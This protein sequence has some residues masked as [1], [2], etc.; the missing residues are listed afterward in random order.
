MRISLL[1]LLI[2]FPP[3]A[4]SSSNAISYQQKLSTEE[5]IQLKIQAEK[6]RRS[7]EGEVNSSSRVNLLEKVWKQ[8]AEQLPEKADSHQNDKP[9]NYRLNN[10][11]AAIDKIMGKWTV[12]YTI[13]S[14]YTDYLTI[15]DRYYSD[16]EGYMGSGK[17][18]SIS[19]SST[20]DV[21]LCGYYAS[22]PIRG[23]NYMCVGVAY[24]DVYQWYWFNLGSSGNSINGKYYIGSSSSAASAVVNSYWYSLYGVKVATVATPTPTVTYTWKTGSWSSCDGKC[25]KNNGTQSREVYC[26]SSTGNK[27][28]DSYCPSS[29][30]PTSSNSC[31]ASVCPINDTTPDTFDVTDLHN[32][33]VDSQVQTDTIV[34]SGINTTTDISTSVGTLVINDV[35]T[36]KKIGSIE[37]GDSVAVYLTTSLSYG[38]AVSGILEIGGVSDTFYVSTMLQ[39]TP[40]PISTPTPTPTPTSTPT[41]VPVITPTPEPIPSPVPTS[42]SETDNQTDGSLLGEGECS[43]DNKAIVASNLDISIPIITYK[44]L[45]GSQSIYLDLEYFGTNSTG[46][47]TWK[48]KAFGASSSCNSESLGI[49]EYDLNIHVD[50][51]QYY[52]IIGSED[53][54]VDLHFSHQ[55][56]NG[57]FW[58]LKEYGV[59]NAEE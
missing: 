32:Q 27:V 15:D 16:S 48:F 49:I 46:D 47:L 33:A 53:I 20:G 55:D 42:G 56:E 18:S 34:V 21:L 44:T 52:T 6:K 54:W 12:S 11:A 41:P 24:G 14:T 28:A 29:T 25:G 26:Q 22:D 37:N 9:Y 59:N 8:F 30:K 2:F 19:H 7:F 40:T 38:A 4:I 31:T 23:Y 5:K 36:G 1:M 39:P 45:L 50:S 35:N 17:V 51:L 43:G 58:T 57:L 13:V 10:N 3:L